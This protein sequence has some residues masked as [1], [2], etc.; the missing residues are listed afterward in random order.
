M[1][2]FLMFVAAVM[3]CISICIL[4]MEDEQFAPR[5][6]YLRPYRADG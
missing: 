6:L 5:V 2:A 4:R 1:C 3:M